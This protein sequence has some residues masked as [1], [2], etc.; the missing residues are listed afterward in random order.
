[1]STVT[2]CAPADIELEI[3]AEADIDIHANISADLKNVCAALHGLYIES[4]VDA[5]IAFNT[6]ILG[7]AT[8][9]ADVQANLPLGLLELVKG[10]ACNLGLGKC[11]YDCV[12]YCAKGCKN[13]I[14][15]GAEIG[16]SIKGLAG[17][18]ILPKVILT[19]NATR[20]I[21]AHVV[22]GLLCLVGGLIKT[23]LSTFDCHCH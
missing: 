8:V 2:F 21:V 17:F 16:A 19:V 6:D 1:M 7:L 23:V 3:A 18:C 11:N 14:D 13:Y 20:H 5:V 12:A 9:T 10:V 4:V 22:D 15:V